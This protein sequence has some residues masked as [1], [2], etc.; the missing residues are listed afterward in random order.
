M[1]HNTCDTVGADNSLEEKLN[2][3][4]GRSVSRINDDFDYTEAVLVHL[5]PFL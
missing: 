2:N 4:L 1:S 5:I 3:Q